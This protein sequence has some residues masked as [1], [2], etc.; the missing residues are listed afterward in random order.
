MRVFLV[1]ILLASVVFIPLTVFSETANT[2]EELAEMYNPEPCAD[3][4]EVIHDEWKNSWHGKSIVDPR[5]LRTWRTFIVRG[6]DKEEKL[7]RKDLKDYCLPCHLPQIKDAT[8]EVGKKIADLV[9]TAVD[10]KG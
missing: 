1:F 8:Y 9:V 5:V 10:E 6:L 7:S 3:C 2:I 4:H